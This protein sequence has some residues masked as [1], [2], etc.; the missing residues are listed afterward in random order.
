[1]LKDW[2]LIAKNQSAREE[3]EV[4]ASCSETVNIC[5]KMKLTDL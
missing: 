3:K 2:A 5:I 4:R 1:M